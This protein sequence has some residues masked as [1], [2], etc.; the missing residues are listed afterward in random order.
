MRTSDSTHNRYIRRT[1]VPDPVP[2]HTSGKMTATNGVGGTAVHYFEFGGWD[3]LVTAVQI[4]WFDA[5]SNAT[6]VLETSNVPTAELTFPSVSTNAYD[7][8]VESTVITGPTAVAAG[9]SMVH[10]ANNGAKRNRLKVTV[11]ADTEMDIIASGVQ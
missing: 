10:I 3:D 9:S 7:W 5:T 2:S 4:R 8:S 1:S 6:I 11:A